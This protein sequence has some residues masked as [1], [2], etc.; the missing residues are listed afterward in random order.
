MMTT[1]ATN[2]YQVW[3]DPGTTSST[4]AYST[5][6]YY[7]PVR[8]YKSTEAPA[9]YKAWK[10]KAEERINEEDVLSVFDKGE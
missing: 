9:E 4:T 1:S 3:Y 10:L 7:K 6:H 8:W 2:Y 5:V